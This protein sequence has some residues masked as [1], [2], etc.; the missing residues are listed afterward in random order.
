MRST[1]MHDF[2]DALTNVI[3]DRSA[4]ELI[5]AVI[6]ALGLALAF[7]G[8]DFISRRN[9]RESRMPMIVIMIAAN[10]VSMAFAAGYVAYLRKSRGAS[11][12]E[13][14]QMASLRLEPV[15]AESIFRAADKNVDGQLSSEEA[16]VAA[17]E[18]VRQA[19]HTGNGSISGPT[20]EHALR[21][22]GS[23]GARRPTSTS[24]QK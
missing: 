10:L 3:V 5:G 11:A 17:A 23:H 20:L 1:T 13:R 12:S 21:P 24:I 2:L 15:L 9:A 22:G 7:T 16:A 8:L 19:D 14:N 4:D 18:F 6:V